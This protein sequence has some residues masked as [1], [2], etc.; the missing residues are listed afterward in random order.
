MPEKNH[1]NERS[2]HPPRSNERERHNRSTDKDNRAGKPIPVTEVTE[3]GIENA[4]NSEYTDGT[5]IGP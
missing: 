4:D 3:Q 1:D 5:N 2:R